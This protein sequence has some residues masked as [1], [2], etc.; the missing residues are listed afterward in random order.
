MENLAKEWEHALSTVTKGLKALKRYVAE[1]NSNLVQEK[2]DNLKRTFQTYE[3]I[4]TTYI[5]QLV[6]GR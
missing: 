5:N 6:T 4:H 2:Y 1:D 3:D